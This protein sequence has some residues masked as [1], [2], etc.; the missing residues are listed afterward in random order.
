MTSTSNKQH[1]TVRTF[2][3]YDSSFRPLN[4]RELKTLLHVFAQGRFMS[5]VTHIPVDDFEVSYE[6]MQG[7]FCVCILIL[8]EQ[9]TPKSPRYITA[10]YRGASRRSYKD[11]RNTVRGEMQAFSRALLYSHAVE[12]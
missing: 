2:N 7:G 4:D 5:S 1:R 12:V 8:F 9:P 10:V 11:A 6:F 3:G